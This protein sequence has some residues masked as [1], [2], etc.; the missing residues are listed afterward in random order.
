MAY[1]PQSD[2]HVV[3][4]V[5]E[6]LESV[7]SSFNR[8]EK[9]KKLATLRPIQLRLLFAAGWLLPCFMGPSGLN[10]FLKGKARWTCNAC[11]S[12]AT[13]LLIQA[14]PQDL[15]G[16]TALLQGCG[17]PEIPSKHQHVSIWHCTAACA[18]PV[19]M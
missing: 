2:A 5:V 8:T 17:R 3:V 11:M 9:A 6:A 13:R 14:P 12:M 18:Q 1:G 19:C 10:P 4:A 15:M 7:H 16:S